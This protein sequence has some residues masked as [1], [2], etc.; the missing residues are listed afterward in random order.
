MSA[1][2]RIERRLPGIL[3]DLGAGASPD[4]TDTILGRTA[5]TRQRP[6]WVFP[7]RWIPMTTTTRRLSAAPNIPWR[8]VALAALLLVGLVITVA[9]I[10]SQRR[11]P[12]PFGPAANGVI[13]YVAHGDIY[14]GDPVAGT[15]RLLVAGPEDDA[16]PQFSPD[17]TR[18][19][20]I[21]D[22][23]TSSARPIDV[24]VVRDDGTALTKIT[25]KPIWNYFW[26]SWTPDGKNLAVISQVETGTNQLDFYDATGDGRVKTI[27]KAPRMNWVQFRPPDGHE[28]LYR[29]LV[30]RTWG[31]YV[32]NADG[33]NPHP[34]GTPTIPEQFDAVYARASY[35]LD[36]KRIFY[37]Y[38]SA[39]P[40]AD[41]GCCQLWV[42]NADGS[43]AHE[44]IKQ[45]GVPGAVWRGEPV[46][47]PDGT[48][49]AY[50]HNYDAATRQISV[51][52]TDETG[53]VIRTGP[54]L[55]GTAHWVWSPDS[56]KILLYPN[57]TS[58][59]SAYLVDPNGGPYTTVPW[60][61]DADIDW[62]R[63][64]TP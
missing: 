60:Q 2:P 30:D 61:S 9:Y 7:G 26:A 34:L 22:V 5:V 10:G 31:L 39:N 35:T 11:V 64:A 25:P 42:M 16:L 29:A 37:E 1:D 44:F 8:M 12:P 17:G 20:F 4:Y 21:R 50:W 53:P 40:N 18:V 48:R 47:S 45:P 32:M 36:G 19:A 51:A 41:Y 54:Q 58:S 23:G 3:A 13:P 43:D 56:S 62:Q 15:S 52:K 28:I 59:S 27:A 57:D 55:P 33:S 24:Y 46:V 38:G 6:G 49:V 63:L 14:L